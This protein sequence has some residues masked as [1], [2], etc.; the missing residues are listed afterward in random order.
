MP[1]FDASRWALTTMP[2]S[3]PTGV[4]EAASAGMAQASISEAAPVRIKF[5]RS[6][7]IISSQKWRLSLRPKATA[8]QAPK[9]YDRIR[10]G[11]P[12]RSGPSPFVTNARAYWPRSPFSVGIGGG[13]G[14]GGAITGQA[15]PTATTLPS[16]HVCVAGGGGGGGAG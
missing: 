11:R 13:G 8:R 1:A 5:S 4:V 16:A 15:A 3:A 14:G 7:I 12:L 2:C 10:K 9:T 6:P